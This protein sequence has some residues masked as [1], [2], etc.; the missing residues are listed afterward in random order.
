[1]TTF[2][3]MV[4]TDAISGPAHVV[5]YTV[6]PIHLY[7]SHSFSDRSVVDTRK[8]TLRCFLSAPI[9]VM[10]VLFDFRR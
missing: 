7:L 2:S 1:M 4:F 5:S 8:V 9:S 3:H 6:H 10:V